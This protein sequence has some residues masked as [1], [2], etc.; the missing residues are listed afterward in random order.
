MKKL[1]VINLIPICLFGN[2]DEVILK[3]SKLDLLEKSRKQVEKS[4]EAI[5]NLWLGG[6]NLESSYNFSE[7]KNKS[8]DYLNFSATVSQDVFRSGGIEYQIE[9]GKIVKNLNMS[10]IDKNEQDLIFLLYSLVLNI[11][12]LDVDL[13][14]QKLLIA[15]QQLII[16]NQQDS[17]LKGVINLDQLDQ[18][19]IE[20]NN[21]KNIEENIISSRIDLIASLKDITDISY[22]KIKIPVLNLPSIDNFLTNNIDL[23]INQ[24]EVYSLDIEKKLAYAQYLPRIAVYGGYQWENSNLFQDEHSSYKYGVKLTVP[25]GFNF[26]DAIEAAQA[27]YL[28]AES[29]YLDQK[30]N[31]KSI[32]D[33]AI[34]KLESI[35]RKLKNNREAIKRYE[36]VLD[37]TEEYYR[38]NLKTANDVTVLKNRVAITKYDSKIYEIESELVKLS[39]IKLLNNKNITRLK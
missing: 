23:D 29:N 14:K 37:T 25:I 11:K 17:Y 27:T 20:L 39:V 5:K 3:E 7:S 15:N 24:K 31:Q 10:I 13:Q 1:L 16:S 36:Q 21:I 33:K 34:L 6:V 18:S 28:K 12:K 38:S 9:K 8:D 19:I 22:N 32:Y 30:E 26:Y 4:S 35:N 2:S